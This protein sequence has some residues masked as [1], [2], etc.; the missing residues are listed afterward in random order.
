VQV[1]IAAA[2]GLPAFDLD[3]PHLPREID[4]AALTSGGFAS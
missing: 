2:P 4:A 3:D 1:A